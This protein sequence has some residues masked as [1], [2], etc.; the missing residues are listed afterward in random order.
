M[1]HVTYQHLERG[2]QELRDLAHGIH[3]SLLAAHGLAAAL[4]EVAARAPVPVTV[5]DE[6]RERLSADVEAALYF[7]SSE[8]VTNAAK[9]ARPTA[10]LVEIGRE[11]GTAYVSV[12]D[13][14]VGGASLERGSGLRGLGDRLATLG[15]TVRIASPAGAG[16]TIVAE[17][18]LGTD[19]GAA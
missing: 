5:V 4:R 1:L 8:A 15:G 17:V 19:P 10:V 11:N 7:A 3:P 14:G 16:T 13:D 9:H 6:L 2:L 18:P 12:R